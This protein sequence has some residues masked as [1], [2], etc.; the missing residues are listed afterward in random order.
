MGAIVLL[1][2]GGLAIY[3]GTQHKPSLTHPIAAP[4][5]A[6]VLRVQ[7]IGLID[8]GPD[9]DGDP[10][11]NDADD[12][13]LMLRLTRHG[14]Q[15]VAIPKAEFAAGVPLWTADQM[16][17]GTEIF[18]YIPSG[19][20]LTE[21]R[22]GTGLELERCDLA[23]HQRWRAV[24]AATVLGQPIAQFASAAGTCLTGGPRPGPARL[25]ACGRARTKS[26]EI[27]FWW[28]A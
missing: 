25:T 9:D 4:L 18:I 23:A 2:G 12:H 7:T 28:S 1:A 5:S 27:A 19:R 21:T 8:F 14:L 16:A 26:Q 20:C 3:L 10:P 24:R 11:T 15:F 17:D 13:P 6:K 22:Q